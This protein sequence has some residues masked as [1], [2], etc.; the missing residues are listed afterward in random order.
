MIGRIKRAAARIDDEHIPGRKLDDGA[1]RLPH[2][3][4]NAAQLPFLPRADPGRGRRLKNG[5]NAFRSVSTP[6]TGD[7][8][9]RF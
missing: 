7:C 5:T 3:Q 8:G 2:V 9:A 6:I 4:K 1:I